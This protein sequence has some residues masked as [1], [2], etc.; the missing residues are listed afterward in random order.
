LWGRIATIERRL[1]HR[2]PWRGMGDHIALE[3]RKR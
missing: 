2:R 1:R 3:F